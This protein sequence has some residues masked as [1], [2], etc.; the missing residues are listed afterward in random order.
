MFAKMTDRWFEC[1]L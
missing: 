1:I